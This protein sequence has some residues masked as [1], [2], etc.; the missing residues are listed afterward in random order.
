LLEKKSLAAAD[1]ARG[2]FRS[3]LIKALNNFLADEYDKARAQKRGGGHKPISLDAQEAENRYRLEPTDSLTP[4]MIFER[5]WGLE[6][7]NHAQ[8]RLR[9]EYVRKGNEALFEALKTFHTGDKS[10][11]SYAELSQRL[12]VPA[13]TLRS[14]VRQM[15][16]RKAQIIREEIKRTV[17]TPEQIDE[18]IRYLL[19]V[20]SR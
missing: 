14:H 13:S 15:N 9:E 3:F 10:E 4:E 5:R 18:E 16:R 2:R 8:R 11:A 1:P 19:S 7:L 6:L 20:V 17:E 12:G